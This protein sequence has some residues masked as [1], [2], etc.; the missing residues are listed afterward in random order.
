MM[1][2]KK[3]AKRPKRSFKLLSILTTLFAIVWLITLWQGTELPHQQ[4]KRLHQQADTTAY[5]SINPAQDLMQRQQHWQQHERLS[6]LADLPPDSR[7]L[8]IK[9]TVSTQCSPKQ[10]C[11]AIVID[12]MGMNRR[13][14]MAANAL[15]APLTMA[16]LP[17]APQVSAQAKASSAAGHELFVHIPMQPHDAMIDAGKNALLVTDTPAIV[18]EKM[19]WH[20][21]RFE[22]FTGFN[23]HMG[24][25]FTENLAAVSLALKAAKPWKPI[26]LDSLTTQNSVLAATAASQ[27][28]QALSRDIFLD[29]EDNSDVI[30]TRLID[31]ASLARKRGYAIAIG[32][33]RAS[34]LSVLAE[35]LPYLQQ[36]GFVLVGLSQ[37]FNTTLAQQR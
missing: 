34:T 5:A 1:F 18:K 17:Y 29:H 11:L 27:G 35:E 7:L 28:F 4:A 32:H 2:L 6:T 31:A 33:P 24:S 21:T 36:D 16:F 37:L 23:N 8:A 30:R 19:H 13:L 25:R 10:P 14:T 9:P 15:P 20:L 26:V 12:D 22:G 3:R